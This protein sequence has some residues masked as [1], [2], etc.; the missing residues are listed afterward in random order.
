M[1]GHTLSLIVLKSQLAARLVH[2]DP[3]RAAAE[4]TDLEAVARSA[5]AQVRT[6]VAGFRAQPLT[7]ALGETERLCA[8]A[9][10]RCEAPPPPKLPA[11]AE[12]LLGLIL[13]EA[14]TNVVRHS[15]ARSCRI[16]FVRD[17]AGVNLTVADDGRG[18]GAVANG[19]GTGLRG[20]RE[21]RAA[22]GG[23]LEIVS[24]PRGG[25]SLRAWLPISETSEAEDHDPSLAR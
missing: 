14:V 12:G 21:R 19:M 10:I 11:E 20:I 1:L 13:R 15:G 18:L 17:T 9:G 7:E 24:H 3:R 4:C 25:T 5:L 22:V 2:E 23:R 6:V 16:A 8:A